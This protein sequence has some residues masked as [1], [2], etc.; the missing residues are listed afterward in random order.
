VTRSPT[1]GVFCHR[2][3]SSGHCHPSTQRRLS[4]LPP[5]PIH[6]LGNMYN[7]SHAHPQSTVHSPQ[8]TVHSPQ[9]T[10]HSP[11][12]TVHSPQSTVHR[13]PSTAHSRQPTI[14]YS[15]P[16][17][18]LR[19]NAPIPCAAR[20]ARLHPMETALLGLVIR[21]L[22]RTSNAAACCYQPATSLLP[23][24]YPPPTHC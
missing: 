6:A 1:N 14:P 2:H 11:Q 16:T 20:A 22:H 3:R 24:C 19:T 10:V 9:S 21:Q 13:P 5:V 15:L 17:S 7:S 18:Y 23:A 12:S 8:S 4:A